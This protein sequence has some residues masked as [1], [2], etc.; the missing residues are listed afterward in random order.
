MEKDTFSVEKASRF[1]LLGKHRAFR[2]PARN[3][4][5]PGRWVFGGWEERAALRGGW[6]NVSD[7]GSPSDDAAAQE[8]SWGQD[9]AEAGAW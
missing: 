7:A 1:S 4:R 2:P 9:G 6:R 5:A 8:G 3:Q